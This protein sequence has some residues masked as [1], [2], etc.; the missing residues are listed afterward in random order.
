[1]VDEADA[2]LADEIRALGMD[3]LVT[4]TVMRSDADRRTLA[5]DVMQFGCLL[6]HPNEEQNGPTKPF[7]T[8]TNTCSSQHRNPPPAI[9]SNARSNVPGRALAPSAANNS[10]NCAVHHAPSPLQ[11]SV[12]REEDTLPEFP[13]WRASLVAAVPVNHLDRAKSR[14]QGAVSDRP[15]LVL[16]MLDHVLGT[17][18]ACPEVSRIAVVTPDPRVLIHVGG[19]R[20]VELL[21]QADGDLNDACAQAARW[22]HAQSA[23]AL[24][25]VHADLP[26]LEPADV[27]GMAALATLERVPV[28]VLA[29]DRRDRGTNAL[30]AA[31]PGAIACCFGD[32]SFRRH[33][34]A[35]AATPVGCQVY[36]APG[37]AC[38]VDT[39][40]DLAEAGLF[41]HA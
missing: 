12:R 35:A 21:L 33:R 8:T 24:L 38:D 31:P 41:G 29:P 37:T 27:S 40:D 19:R 28:V 10:S 34:E 22:A 17:L 15:A 32:D 39:A 16:D 23:T 20:G 2:G 3:V 36:R 14:L 5:V 30:L 11:T 26:C 1:V 7:C 18:E 25:L 6:P 9:V 13:P 4:R